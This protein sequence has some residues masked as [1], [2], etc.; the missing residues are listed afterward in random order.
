[1]VCNVGINDM[2]WG[3]K[4]ENDYNK[5]VYSLWREMIRR[6]YSEQKLK[7]NPTYECCYVCERWKKL[8]NFV[9]DIEKIENYNLW[10]KNKD[11]ELDKDIKTNGKNKEY[12]LEN[13][14]FVSHSE[15]IRQANKTR[16]YDDVRGGNAVQSKT[17][18]QYDM[19]MNLIKVWD[20][21][22]IAQVEKELKISHIS[23]CCN[24]KRKSA[25]GYIWKHKEDC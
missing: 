24:N 19:N 4:S 14:M 2:Y 12:C 3:W 13:C 17:V 1:M 22:S 18:I 5:R 8:S 7:V 6:C 25:G 21:Y 11:Y 23:D 20:N 16:N 15:N 10:I 9:E